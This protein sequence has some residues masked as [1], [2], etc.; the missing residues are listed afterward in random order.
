MKRRANGEGALFQRKDGRWCARIHVN[1]QAHYK[2]ARNQRE[3]R[4]WLLE[5]RRQIA[6]GLLLDQGKTPL[7]DY[8]DFWLESIK[9][10]L[11]PKT[12][13]QY[14]QI[15]RQH[16]KP[17]LGRV[18][19]Q[20]L[21]PDQLQAFYNRRQADKASP[22]TVQLIHAVL[23]RSLGQAMK[24][25]LMARNPADA[26][27]R[28]RVA[29][30]EMQVLS[31]EQ[32]Q[33]LLIAATGDRLEALWHLAI[34]TGMRMGELLGL[35]WSDVDWE[36]S[37]VQIQRQLQRIP[38]QGLVF[39]QPKSEKGK[40]AIAVGNGT[41]DVLR[42]H[43]SRQDEERSATDQWQ[44][45]DLVFPSTIGTPMEPRNLLRK[46]K[47]LLKQAGLPEIRFHDLRHTSATLMLKKS[48][49]PKIVQERLGHASINLTLDTYTH[50]LPHMQGDAAEIMDKLTTL[51]KAE[52]I[53][54][55]VE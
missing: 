6:D 50:V 13:I 4:D 47:F 37:E 14:E 41:L 34:V 12:W 51:I 15:T 39:A 8:L 5:M 20:D 9:P 42:D 38:G 54:P 1:G 35:R 43:H 48:V 19:L 45:L 46:F 16:I 29:K 52:L 30:T 53:R 36:T 23:H 11:R 3:C 22:R 18:R 21:R 26:V 7:A 2:Y 32:V 49:H 17:E 31:E 27:E 24:W 28:P 40:R 10:S 55:S 44:S 25:G 33:R